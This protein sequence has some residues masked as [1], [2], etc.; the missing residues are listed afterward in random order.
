MRQRELS[1]ETPGG[2]GAHRNGSFASWL[3][4]GQDQW[5]VKF[6]I[7]HNLEDRERERHTGED[8]KN[9]DIKLFDEEP[10]LHWEG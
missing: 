1:P 9:L 2:A 7:G 6:F 8:K 5:S 3:P 10:S 4:I